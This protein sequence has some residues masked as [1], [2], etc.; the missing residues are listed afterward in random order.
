VKTFYIIGIV[1]LILFNGCD[2]PVEKKDI[3]LK[4]EVITIEGCEYIMY[5]TWSPYKGYGFM[6]HK[7]NCINTI[8]W[9]R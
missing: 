6:A 3:L 7:G 5:S 9:K 2:N 1:L 8:H 4:Y